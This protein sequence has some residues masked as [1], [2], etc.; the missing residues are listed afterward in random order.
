MT[1]ASLLLYS[2]DRSAT[3]KTQVPV[4][5][6]KLTYKGSP[7]SQHQ[8]EVRPPVGDSSKR[9]LFSQSS[10]G[11]KVVVGPSQ[12]LS[13]LSKPEAS[14]N[15]KDMTSFE[16]ALQYQEAS[17]R[18]VL[19]LGKTA[20]EGIIKS[21][22]V[23]PYG[24]MLQID[25]QDED[26]DT[27]IVH[28]ATSKGDRVILLSEPRL[29]ISSCEPYELQQILL[30]GE[31]MITALHP[32]ISG[33]VAF[34]ETV[35]ELLENEEA[36]EVEARTHVLVFSRKEH[37]RLK[38][39]VQ[40]KPIKKPRVQESDSDSEE[41]DEVSEKDVVTLGGELSSGIVASE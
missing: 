36:E 15:P 14:N 35:D 4:K 10:Q 28:V 18:L 37:K 22:R 19:V 26:S 34:E 40:K 20:G 31:N 8:K 21:G 29:V 7:L 39:R 30:K 16:W 32:F 12:K 41:S 11:G 9:V 25:Y 6:L 5:R 13:S 33:I 17:K 24:K 1:C 27:F 3:E 2:I 38:Q 23:F